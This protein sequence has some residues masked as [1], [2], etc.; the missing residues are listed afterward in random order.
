MKFLS[1]AE[2]LAQWP[3]TRKQGKLRFIAKHV[4]LM[5]AAY[6][7]IHILLTLWWGDELRPIKI[8]LSI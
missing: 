7:G 8:F 6:C 3:E 5:T 4:L 2:R 1:H